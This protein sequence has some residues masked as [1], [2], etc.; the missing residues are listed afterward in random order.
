MA[1]TAERHVDDSNFSLIRDGVES[2]LTDSD[3]EETREW[4]ES[5]DGLLEEAGPD[6][7]RFLMLRLLERATAKRVALPPLTS[8]DYVN[9][10]PTT[11]EPEFPGDEAV[12]RRY[13]KWIRWNAAIMVH[14]AQRPG[15]GVGGHISTYASSAPL[16]EVG[17]NHFFRGKDVVVVGASNHAEIWDKSRWD[18]ECAK[19]DSDDIAGIMDELGF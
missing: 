4:L 10:I 17:F 6:R 11:M 18:A 12:E 8:T 3:P 5:L 13:R 16:Y 1:D 19:L 14:R 2:Y 15:I 9:T 7:A